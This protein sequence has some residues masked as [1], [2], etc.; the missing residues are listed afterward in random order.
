MYEQFTTFVPHSVNTTIMPKRM[1]FY[2]IRLDIKL[3]KKRMQRHI[4]IQ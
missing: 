3:Y 2:S 1:E 4:T